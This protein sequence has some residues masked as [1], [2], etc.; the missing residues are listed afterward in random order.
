VA[1]VCK[2]Y[3]ETQNPRD[4]FGDIQRAVGRLA[5]ELPEGGFTPQLLD[6][7]WSK[8]AAIMVCQDQDTC[9][10]FAGSAPTLTAWE[11]ARFKV[12]GMD[13]LPVFKRVSAWFPG[14]PGAT[15][16]LFRRLRLL[17]RG[18]EPR[19]WRVYERK[20]EP[21]G[22]RLVLSVRPSYRQHAGGE[23]VEGLQR[24]GTSHLLPS[25]RQA[26]GEEIDG[27]PFERWSGGGGELEYG[28]YNLI[29]S[30]QPAAQRCCF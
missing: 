4:M 29:Y 13:A 22:V 21:H 2:D 16:T 26:V 15:E 1:I 14:P 18:L 7:Y 17:N 30:G 12:V 23:V 8:G 3:P 10:W 28:E 25:G 27:T 24:H 11:G 20:E 19:Q 5:D 6:T 9:D